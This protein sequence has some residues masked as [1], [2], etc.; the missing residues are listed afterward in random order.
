MFD[1]DKLA[2]IQRK[3][4]LFYAAAN[5]LNNQS[6]KS[7]STTFSGRAAVTTFSGLA[8]LPLQRLVD[9]S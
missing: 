2:T 4:K 1:A 7:P 5:A 6:F 3:L 9:Y 8:E